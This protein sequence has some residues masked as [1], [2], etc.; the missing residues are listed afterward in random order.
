MP[1]EITIKIFFIKT[2]KKPLNISLP[3]ALYFVVF[4][5]CFLCVTQHFLVLLCGEAMTQRY[6]KDSQNSAKKRFQQY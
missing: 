5:I 4:F 3:A 1:D 2:K 6:S